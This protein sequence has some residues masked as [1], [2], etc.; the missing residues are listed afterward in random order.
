LGKKPRSYN[1]QKDLR[2]HIK[3]IN[4]ELVLPEDYE[5]FLEL[6]STDRR[7]KPN[8]A[9]LITIDLAKIS[10]IRL[11]YSIRNKKNKFFT[12]SLYEIN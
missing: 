4:R 11:Y 7:K 8:Q 2:E 9:K 6:R 12:I 1:Y 3:I 10:A 5:F